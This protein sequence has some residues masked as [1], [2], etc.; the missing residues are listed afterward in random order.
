MSRTQNLLWNSCGNTREAGPWREETHTTVTL[1]RRDFET[2]PRSPR[3][4][5]ENEDGSVAGGATTCPNSHK[6]HGT[7]T[8]ARFIK[9]HPAFRADQPERDYENYVCM[10]M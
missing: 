8:E 4:P 2:T 3:E 9:L 5:F 7:A 1:E 6:M 10:I